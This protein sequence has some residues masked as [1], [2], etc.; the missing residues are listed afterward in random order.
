ML[1][2]KDDLNIDG[3]YQRDQVSESKVLEIA[4]DWDWKLF[5]TLA[6]VER[7]DGSFWIYDG[8]HRARASFYR[9]DITKLPCMVFQIDS[10]TEEAKAFVGTNTMGSYVSAYHK[11]RASVIAG[12]PTAIA[13]QTLL[14]KYGLAVSET[15]KKPGS[16]S[17][18]NTLR[19]LVSLNRIMAERVLSACVLIANGRDVIT[20]TVMDGIYYCQHK[21]KGSDDIL[22]GAHLEKLVHEGIPGIESAIRR[23]KHLIGKGGAMVAAKAVLDVLNKGKRRR[24]QFQ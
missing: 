7:A 18:V 4:R 22:A 5:G 13:V 8:G 14:D 1:I 19:D 23:E 16:F 9:D 11:H 15:A 6:V 2:G 17:A 20:G 24:L 3:T 21:L 10:Q 12:E